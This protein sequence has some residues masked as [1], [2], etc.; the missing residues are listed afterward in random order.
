MKLSV[1]LH[2]YVAET[3][4]TYGTL[5]E[6]T[7]RILSLADEG[8]ID[9]ADKPVCEPR[10]GANRY[11]IN[12][13]NETYLNSLELHGFKSKFISLRRLLYWFVNDEIY[14]TLDWETKNDYICKKDAQVNKRI[15]EIVQRLER[16]K[17]LT[18][19][20]IVDKCIS[21]LNDLRR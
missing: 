6:V 20:Q 21:M 17:L 3:L 18:R 4:L 10:D 8:V 15:D 16:L 11:D 19:E 13:T 5:D 7:N 2:D 1:Y 9:F 12:V 14:L